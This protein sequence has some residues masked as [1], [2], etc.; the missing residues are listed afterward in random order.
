[1]RLGHEGKIAKYARAAEIK[2]LD[3]R[4]FDPAVPRNKR[5]PIVV[6]GFARLAVDDLEQNAHADERR[7]E[8]DVEPR[9]SLS[10]FIGEEKRGDE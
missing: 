7:V 1:M 10:R 5:R 8:I 9:K 4:E 2:E 6:N 3:P